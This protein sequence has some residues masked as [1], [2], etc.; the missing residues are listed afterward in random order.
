[1]NSSRTSAPR[2]RGPRSSELEQRF[3]IISRTSASRRPCCPPRLRSARVWSSAGPGAVSAASAAPTEQCTRVDLPG[4]PGVELF[5]QDVF[6]GDPN[7]PAVASFVR[8]K[9]YEALMHHYLMTRR[10]ATQDFVSQ[11]KDLEYWIAPKTYWS[12]IWPSALVLAQWILEHGE[13]VRGKRC[14]E[15]GAGMGLPGSTSAL[16]STAPSQCSCNIARHLKL[17]LQT[18]SNQA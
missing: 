2:H 10:R 9:S 11:D 14:I 15:L 1:M 18:L 4:A 7:A 5:V 8:P 16:P 17:P 3:A 13:Q 12:L 6:N